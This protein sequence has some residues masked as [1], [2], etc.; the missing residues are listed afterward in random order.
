MTSTTLTDTATQTATVTAYAQC[1]AT[2]F[3]DH[4][5]NGDLG[6][7]DLPPATANVL[8]TTATDMYACCVACVKNGA[9]SLGGFLGGFFV[10]NCVIVG[11]ASCDPHTPHTYGITEVPTTGVPFSFFNGNCGQIDSYDN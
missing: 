6:A 1:A 2:N 4:G 7:P 8:A 9:C 5:P 10:N 3:A 11:E